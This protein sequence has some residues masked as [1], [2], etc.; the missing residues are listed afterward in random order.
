[1]PVKLISRFYSTHIPLKSSM[2]RISLQET[3]LILDQ[4]IAHCPWWHCASI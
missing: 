2:K 3:N 4:M 1:M